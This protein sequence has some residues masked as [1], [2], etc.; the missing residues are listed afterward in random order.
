MPPRK[1]PFQNEVGEI[2]APIFARASVLDNGLIGK[3]PANKSSLTESNGYPQPSNAADD[4]YALNSLQLRRNRH[5]EPTSLIYSIYY[6][7]DCLPREL[8]KRVKTWG[9]GDVL[10]FNCPKSDFNAKAQEH[11]KNDE[12]FWNTIKKSEFF[13]WPI[14]AEPG[15]FVTAIFH[16]QKGMTDDPDF[17][18]TLKHG[19]KKP[20]K[21]QSNEYTIV[22]H[23]SVVD[24]VRSNE[25]TQRENRVK[26]RIQRLFAI[27][28]LTF[29]QHSYREQKTAKGRWALPWVP[30]Q[31]DSWSSGLRSFALVRQLLE[32]IV[33]LYCTE[34]GYNDSF[35]Q[36]PTSGWIN[37]DQIRH[38]M[39]GYCAMNCIEDMNY[40]ARIAIEA[41]NEIN[42]IEGIAS[43]PAN[44]LMP[45]NRDKSAWV[46]ESDNNGVV[47][48][49]T[50][51]DYL[52]DVNVTNPGAMQA[53]SPESTS[54]SS[55]SPSPPPP[56]PPPDPSNAHN[57]LPPD[58]PVVMPPPKNPSKAKSP[59]TSKAVKPS[60]STSAS[61]SSTP[62]PVS[63]WSVGSLSPPPIPQGSYSSSSESE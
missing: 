37:V 31:T 52:D 40:N 27:E 6:L 44:R 8:R 54:S 13:L 50:I 29:R 48:T 24:P 17:D 5:I 1:R 10:V 59:K 20:L 38:E 7:L 2:D 41:I 11:Y 32:R 34:L 57:P 61:P 25:G 22:E 14:E 4:L 62:S 19:P 3:K 47:Q 43:F 21:V 63:D 45:Y 42:S 18:P 15:H 26:K 9:P 46:P 28:G 33:D 16:L 23:W 12:Q 51:S 55:P 36:K 30:P 39:M 53:S 56:P 49:P 58:S 60:Q 35:F